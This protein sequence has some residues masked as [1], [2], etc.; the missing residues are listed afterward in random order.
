MTDKI[1]QPSEPVVETEPASPD[2]RA[3]LQTILE[4]EFA[5]KLKATKVLPDAASAALVSLLSASEPTTE[6]VFEALS[7]EDPIEPEV[8]SE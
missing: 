5:V 1:A 2:L 3:E 7:L 4:T 8:T 6:D